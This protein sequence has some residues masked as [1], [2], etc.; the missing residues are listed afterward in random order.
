MAAEQVKAQISKAWSTHQSGN[1]K[2]AINEFEQIL[3]QDQNNVDAMYG[4]GLAQ[5][6][7]GDHAQAHNSFESA[8]KLVEEAINKRL[9][10][11]GTDSAMSRSSVE[12]D[13][14]LILQRMLKQR[15]AELNG[16]G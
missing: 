6:K 7:A 5:R 10:A 13:R 4:L 1:A 2:S 8:L 14:N 12:N 9:T 15:L 3:K 11:L 16:R